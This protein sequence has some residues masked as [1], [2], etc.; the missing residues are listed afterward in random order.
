MP[1]KLICNKIMDVGTP[2]LDLGNIL[3]I[4]INFE[5]KRHKLDKSGI[6]WQEKAFGFDDPFRFNIN[7]RKVFENTPRLRLKAS[8]S[9]VSPR[10]LTH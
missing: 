10:T 7:P 3:K 1:P 8:R 5:K 4:K 9:A 6:Y 2:P